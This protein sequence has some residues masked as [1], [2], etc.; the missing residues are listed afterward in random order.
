[1]TLGHEQKYPP[2]RVVLTDKPC[3]NCYNGFCSYLDADAIG[4]NAVQKGKLICIGCNDEM[5][6][7]AFEHV[8]L[9]KVY[10]SRDR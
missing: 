3:S 5:S 10:E 4:S 7:G 2:G 1:M 6:S 8:S 9:D